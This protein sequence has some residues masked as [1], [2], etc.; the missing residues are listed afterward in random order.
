LPGNG[1]QFLIDY[2]VAY[3]TH[4]QIMGCRN[5]IFCFLCSDFFIDRMT[6]LISIKCPIISYHLYFSIYFLVFLLHLSFLQGL[7]ISYYLFLYNFLIFRLCLLPTPA[8]I[9]FSWS[10]AVLLQSL[11]KI[12]HITRKDG[13]IFCSLM[14]PYFLSL[15]TLRIIF[16]RYA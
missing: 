1:N 10:V 4:H 12:P 9:V 16:V 14:F 13:N 5:S 15:Q 8:V 6:Y 7:L 3:L 2:W 11:R